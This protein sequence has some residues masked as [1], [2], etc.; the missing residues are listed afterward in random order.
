[1]VKINLAD[2]KKNCLK[3]RN[4]D[5]YGTGILIRL[6]NK[7]V[8]MILTAAHC[9]EGT[10]AKDFVFFN[11]SYKVLTV[12]KSNDKELDFACIIIQK[13]LD[14]VA[15]WFMADELKVEGFGN[16]QF[17]IY[18]YPGVKTE[19]DI[20]D[21]MYN[22]KYLKVVN[23]NYKF[24]LIE[25][26]ETKRRE[27]KILIDG[28]SGSPVVVEENEKI[29]LAGIYNK[30]EHY[31]LAYD[32]INVISINKIFAELREQDLVYFKKGDYREGIVW[33]DNNNNNN[34]EN[35][36]REKISVLLIGKSGSGKSA[37][38][39]S[40]LKHSNII[41]SSGN[42]QT[43]R[44]SI[45]YNIFSGLKKDKCEIEIVFLNKENFVKLRMEQINKKLLDLIKDNEF[46]DENII[47]K[48]LFNLLVHINGFYDYRELDFET[49]ISSNIKYEYSLWFKDGNVKEKYTTEEYEFFKSKLQNANSNEKEK[50]IERE[51]IYGI[52][53]VIELFYEKIYDI[54]SEV[55]KKL[56]RKVK[57]NK[58]ISDEQ[59]KYINYCL[60]VINEDGKNLSYTG[61]ISKIIINDRICDEYIQTLDDLNID[62]ITFI[63]TYGLDHDEE[64]KR[65]NLIERLPKIFDNYQEIQTVFYIRKLNSDAPTDLAMTIPTMYEINP[66][67]TLYVIFSEIDKNDL[68]VQEHKESKIIDLLKLNRKNQIKAVNY[69]IEDEEEDECF[70]EEHPIKSTM[71]KNN[72]SDELSKS[73]Y[74][75]LIDKITP[76]CASV[77]MLDRQEFIDNNISHAHKLFKSII[78]REHLGNNIINIKKIEENIKNG[79]IFSDTIKILLIQMFNEAKI[80]DWNTCGYEHGHWKTQDANI[81]RIQ[82][83]ILGY[84]GTYCDTWNQ[85]FFEAYIK[86]F[87]KLSDEDFEKLFGIDSRLNQSATIRKLLNHF[88]NY[89][90]GCRKYDASKFMLHKDSCIGCA[91][92]EFCFR[93]VLMKSYKPNELSQICNNR[94]NWLN[95]R[96]NFDKRVNLILGDLCNLFINKF[97]SN[98]I[99]DCKLHNAR[100]VSHEIKKT[101]GDYIEKIKEK[102]YS[103]IQK[104]E[105]VVTKERFDEFISEIDIFNYSAL[106]VDE[107]K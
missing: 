37:F 2:V 14:G 100:I 96:C 95:D 105:G 15:E 53:D 76:Y 5:S 38:I 6:E 106:D 24:K 22:T 81:D 7:D 1:M 72:M 9:I 59:K 13:S 33:I 12:W 67:V 4:K 50:Q 57:L 58:N 97:L 71:K 56:P 101:Y 29:L 34:N 107:C 86:I 82:D 75:V 31:D 73:I 35:I 26:D 32:E 64:L 3:F 80:T 25:T 93:E 63:D 77:N 99:L 8:D 47:F 78:N 11:K 41:D 45:E 66:N 62:K 27:K 42:G 88:S 103:C 17:K 51:I 44:T 70:R 54:T 16:E 28:M 55:I 98:F 20:Q 68:I 79:D 91:Y 89:F 36:K 61:I 43:T 39:N 21:E 65:E 102:I 83:G 84:W 92:K 10:K 74:D 60:K 18:G 94:P 30:C 69:F 19:K 23:E 87:S 48:R 40:F 104:N 90:I 46:I 52:N 49:N 85:K